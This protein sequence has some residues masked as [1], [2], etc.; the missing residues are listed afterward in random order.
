[1]IHVGYTQLNG[2]VSGNPGGPQ[3]DGKSPRQSLTPGKR[4]GLT[5]SLYLSFP[6]FSLVFPESV[7]LGLRIRIPSVQIGRI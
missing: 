4:I 6:F 5:H 2:D 7:Y 1:M 3:G